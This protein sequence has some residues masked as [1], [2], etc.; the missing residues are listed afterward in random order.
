[1]A[2][3]R[4]LCIALLSV[5]SHAANTGLAQTE[6]ADQHHTVNETLNTAEPGHESFFT[7]FAT[8]S[9]IRTHIRRAAHS[10][11]EEESLMLP[12]KH[13][14]TFYPRHTSISISTTTAI[15]PSL[16]VRQD[17]PATSSSCVPHT[18]ESVLATCTPMAG[19]AS[20]QICRARSTATIT[21]CDVVDVTSSTTVASTITAYC[22][23][24]GGCGG[25]AC[26]GNEKRM[27]QS[28]CETCS[29]METGAADPGFGRKDSAVDLGD[30]VQVKAPDDRE[31]ISGPLDEVDDYDNY[32]D[33]VVKES[34][35]SLPDNDVTHRI[36][37]TSIARP[38]Q[39][40]QF[41]VG[42]R[43]LYGCTSVIAVSRRG[44]WMSHIW[45][46]PT[47]S[48]DKGTEADLT[49]WLDQAQI[50][51][52]TGDG[53]NYL[54]GLNQF[55]AGDPDASFFDSMKYGQTT[56]KVTVFIV[57]PAKAGAK[58]ETPKSP[59]ESVKYPAEI[60]RLWTA[61][62][63]TYNNVKVATYDDSHGATDPALRDAKLAAGKGR[64]FIQYTPRANKPPDPAP[65][66]GQ[67]GSSTNP[68]PACEKQQAHLRLWVYG[69]PDEKIPL[70]EDKWDAMPNQ[71]VFEP[72]SDDDEDSES[73]SEDDSDSDKRAL[74]P[75]ADTTTSKGSCVWF[76]DITTS[77]A[78]ATSTTSRGLRLTTMATMT[79]PLSCQITY[80]TATSASE[81]SYCTCND[82]QAHGAFTTTGD[83]GGVTVMCNPKGPQGTPVPGDF[84]LT[85]VT[86]WKA[87]VCRVKMQE[88]FSASDPDL[89]VNQVPVTIKTQT[90]DAAGIMMTSDSLV[91][92]EFPNGIVSVLSNSRMGFPYFLQ[93]F[94]HGDPGLVYLKQHSWAF[95]VTSNANEAYNLNWNTDENGDEPS[96]TYP[97]CTVD[98]WKQNQDEY[99]RAIQC[100]W[101]C[102]DDPNQ[103]VGNPAQAKP[104][105]SPFPTAEPELG[106]GCPVQHCD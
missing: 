35:K 9:R 43:G 24:S 40:E 81:V 19:K 89:Q 59:F 28:I 55:T 37:S 5:A 51:I 73:G 15:T 7:T 8:S 42:V 52:F 22:D 88:S 58:L 1:M 4:R 33:F 90:Y 77:T 25:A 68:A 11:I 92:T 65:A 102:G 69:N 86:P 95:L 3:L 6:V 76:G 27:A 17:E 79:G 30:L 101:E 48:S 75:R 97:R 71:I 57:T 91:D 94:K 53:T 21:G 83:G 84:S 67:P 82:D 78:R 87:G 12:S 47:F 46:V 14:P 66:G 96:G 44:A 20:G 98:E 105:K 62:D 100:W 16:A 64:A 23:S 99:S 61:L 60:Q 13:M 29:P 34:D 26:Q 41:N 103:I 74:N 93:I 10:E 70:F 50:G 32:P 106:S 45:E 104:S 56:N 49:T 54:P 39:D 31:V 36:G 18:A 85:G 63:G 2:T 38:F 72:P 80:A